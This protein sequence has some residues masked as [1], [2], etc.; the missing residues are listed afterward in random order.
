LRGTIPRGTQT[1]ER[2]LTEALRPYRERLERE[3]AAWIPR[4]ASTDG[5]APGMPHDAHRTGK[6]SVLD[7]I[8][9]VVAA[10]GKRLRPILCLLATEAAG[11]DADDAIGTAV[12]LEYLHTFT[13]VHDDVMDND[14]LRRGQP[15]VHALWGGPLAITAG[16][17]LYALAMAALLDPANGEASTRTRIALRAAD[18]C[19]ALCAGQTRDI[20]FEARSEVTPEEYHTMIHQKTAVLMGLATE[21]GAIIAGAGEE[22]IRDLHEYGERLGLAFQVK[23]DLLDLEG[24]EA[25]TGKPVGSDIRA[26]KKT[27][28]VVHALAHLD[29][30]PRKRLA[31]ILQTAPAKTTEKMVRE[32][33]DLL[34]SAGSLKAAA[35]HADAL[36]AEAKKALKRFTTRQ[37]TRSDRQHDAADALERIVDHVVKRRS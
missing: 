28:P 33:Y 8:R 9:H 34:A 25:E 24:T 32:A 2:D 21:A 1:K 17:G 23:D 18:V 19:F 29:G 10:G 4:L 7:P 12:G 5:D 3:L 6:G 14:L 22:A 16:D 31:T 35:S 27:Y 11:G 37:K 26:G 13:L 36:A 15:T 20:L 30:A